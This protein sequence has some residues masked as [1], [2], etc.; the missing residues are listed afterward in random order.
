ME[1]TIST[2]LIISLVL[3]TSSVIVFF[4]LLIQILNI[5]KRVLTKIELRIDNLSIT[6]EEIKIK[7]LNIIEEILI[8]IKNY[9]KNTKTKIT[10]DLI[11]K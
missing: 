9:G 8:K 3:I 11:D 1:S 2:L 5:F 4:I 10:K 6:Q 7:I